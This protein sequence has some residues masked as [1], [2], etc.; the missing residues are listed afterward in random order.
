M[1]KTVARIAIH[2]VVFLIDLP[3]IWAPWSIFHMT[4]SP[5]AAGVCD[6]TAFH[7]V[8]LPRGLHILLHHADDA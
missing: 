3:A 5:P 7:L 8:S 6:M 4:Q 2:A 1:T